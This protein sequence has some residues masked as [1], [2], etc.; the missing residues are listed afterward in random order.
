MHAINSFS[1]KPKDLDVSI[2]EMFMYLLRQK[3]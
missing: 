1:S 2:E 3:I